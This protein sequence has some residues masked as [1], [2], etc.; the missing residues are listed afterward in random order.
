MVYSLLLLYFR[1]LI[2]AIEK[3]LVVSHRLVL[4]LILLAI[5]NAIAF[6]GCFAPSQN[7]FTE[8]NLTKGDR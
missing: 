1:R 2:I 6:G 5:E 4:T 7:P 8:L 3:R